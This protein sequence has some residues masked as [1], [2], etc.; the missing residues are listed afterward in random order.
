MSPVSQA[1]DLLLQAATHG[2]DALRVEAEPVHPPDVARVLDFQAAVHDDRHAA[3]F[4][5]ARRF[6]GHLRRI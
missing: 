5:D 3:S 4:G 1:W 6:L 2:C